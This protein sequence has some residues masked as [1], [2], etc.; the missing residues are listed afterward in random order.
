MKKKLLCMMLSIAVVFSFIPLFTV[1]ADAASSNGPTTYIKTRTVTIKP[2]K[3]YKSPTFKI[4]K[5]QAF[6][7]PIYITLPNDDTDE[8]YKLKYTMS[9]KNSKGKTV[10]SYSLPAQTIY[11]YM[12]GTSIYSNWIYF[13]KKSISKPHYDK[14]KYYITIKNTS[15]RTIKVK[16][17][18]KGYS[19]F[20]TTAN[21]KKSLKIDGD[22]LQI[23]AGK[24]GSGIP[25]IKSVK[26]SNKN[27]P[28]D[29]IVEPDGKF[30]L[31]PDVFRDN[32]KKRT[33]TVTVTLK[34]GGK[35]Y[36]IKV[37]DYPVSYD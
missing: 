9:L 15:K 4:T 28:I 2:G 7:V 6:Q 13:Y 24:I 18:V 16:Y 8:Y 25:L 1:Q 35:Q 26:S 32:S 27:V 12:D 33:T 34:N 20:S 22:T 14:G 19:K 11:S 30:Y 29:Y 3:T 37:T 31:V 10:D 23:Y 17:S 36:K 21:I 5:K